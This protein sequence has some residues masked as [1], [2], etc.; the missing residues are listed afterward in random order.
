MAT[1]ESTSRRS[2]LKAAV[3]LTAST[4][5]LPALAG[6]APADAKLR[7]LWVIYLDRMRLCAAAEGPYLAADKAT[8]AEVPAPHT[9]PWPDTYRSEFERASEKYGRSRFYDSWNEADSAV[10]EVVE[11]IRV[12]P[13][14]GVFGIGVKLAALGAWTE[15][16][17]VL[18]AVTSAVA[19]IE[20][21]TGV[22]F[23]CEHFATDEEDPAA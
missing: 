3:A 17:D 12:T 6:V 22:A 16:A 20:R 8:M 10:R 13:A 21:L 7:R 11:L 19:D 9:M 15:E 5:A 23:P 14:E 4:A 2:M 1:N 18:D